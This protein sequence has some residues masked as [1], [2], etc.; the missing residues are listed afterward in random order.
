MT[1]APRW[2]DWPFDHAWYFV[3]SDPKIPGRVKITDE[4]Q[5]GTN[6]WDIHVRTFDKIAQDYMRE[7]DT[8]VGQ[9][10]EMGDKKLFHVPYRGLDDEADLMLQRGM[11]P[12]PETEPL[13]IVTTEGVKLENVPRNWWNDLIVRHIQQRKTQPAVPIDVGNG[14]TLTVSFEFFDGICKDFIRR[15]G[16]MIAAEMWPELHMKDE[17]QFEE[18]PRPV[19]GRG[20]ALSKSDVMGPA[21][22]QQGPAYPPPPGVPGGITNPGA[23]NQE[24]V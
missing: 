14:Q 21:Q 4:P 3:E 19:T 11:E 23:E 20:S 16:D 5:G 7:R 8:K 24:L 13:T 2:Q 12:G 10:I 6:F 9:A 15:R 17:G 18:G 22:Q 1:R